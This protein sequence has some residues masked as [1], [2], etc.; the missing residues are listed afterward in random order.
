M[1]SRISRVVAALV[2]AA[3]VFT[4][5]S[6][7]LAACDSEQ[8]NP[9]ICVAHCTSDFQTVGVPVVL[10]AAWETPVL[11]LPRID[12]SAAPSWR[13]Q[14]PPPLAV[15]PRILYQSLLI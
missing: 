15:P 8:M 6:V 4:Q 7:V 1:A 3:F 11:I 2:L 9:N 12:W 10:L 14:H 13:V 5:A